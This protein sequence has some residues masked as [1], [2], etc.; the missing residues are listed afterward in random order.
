MKKRFIIEEEFDS[1]QPSGYLI[2]EIGED[3]E[4]IEE[5]LK[6]SLRGWSLREIPSLDV[7]EI[8]NTTKRM[9]LRKAPIEEYDLSN[10]VV[11]EVLENYEL[12]FNAK[13]NRRIFRWI[14]R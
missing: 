8:V 4:E 5:I 3:F 2:L 7:V 11:K 9:I 6:E 10:T 1:L 14:Y 12:N 13:H